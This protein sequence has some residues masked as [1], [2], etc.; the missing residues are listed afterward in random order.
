MNVNIF[1]GEEEGGS[2]ETG[3]F[4][5]GTCLLNVYNNYCVYKLCYVGLEGSSNRRNGVEPLQTYS[6]LL[7]R[8]AKRSMRAGKL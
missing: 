7:C 2:G 6:I 5:I 8:S 3:I 4:Y 1:I